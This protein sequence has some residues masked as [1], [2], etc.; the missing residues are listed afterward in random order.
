MNP[1]PFDLA[2]FRKPTKPA[3]PSPAPQQAPEPTAEPE[4]AKTPETPRETPEQA[5]EPNEAATE[6]AG[7]AVAT[8]GEAT[9]P[10]RRRAPRAPGPASDGRLVVALPVTLRDR[11]RAVAASHGETYA[12]V[13]LRAI[14]ETHSRLPGLITAHRGTAGPAIGDLFEHRAKPKRV[15]EATAQVT[16]RGLSAHDRGVLDQLVDDVGAANLTELVTIALDENLPARP[17]AMR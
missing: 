8:G 5:P 14:Q 15:V 17:R 12:E 16:I 11:A 4:S 1:D 3:Q 2:G 9:P 13:V 10:R 7:R 6:P